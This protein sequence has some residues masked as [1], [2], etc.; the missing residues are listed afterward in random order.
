MDSVSK[1]KSEMLSLLDL[2]LQRVL[3]RE[4]SAILRHPSVDS[5]LQ[6]YA[7]ACSEI[8]PQRQLQVEHVL[9]TRTATDDCRREG[10][11]TRVG[12]L[13]SLQ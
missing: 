8:L 4:L 5:Q 13:E 9:V 7:Y 10:L 11:V 3:P 12:D 1:I 6:L 2:Q